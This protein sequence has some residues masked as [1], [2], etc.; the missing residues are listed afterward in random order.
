MHKWLTKTPHKQ[1]VYSAWA[2]QFAD[3]LKYSTTESNFVGLAGNLGMYACGLPIGMLVDKK[4]PRP[5]VL[6]GSIMLAVGYF[7]LYMAYNAGSGSVLLMCLFSF[8]TGLGGCTAFAA[9]IKTSALN[10]LVARPSG[11]SWDRGR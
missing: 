11:V 8:L 9:A 2:P 6:L 4:G 1:Y 10:W 7:P 5:A 3:R